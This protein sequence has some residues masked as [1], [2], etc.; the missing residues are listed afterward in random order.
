MICGADANIDRMS[1]NSDIDKLAENLFLH[2]VS[3]KKSFHIVTSQTT[4]KLIQYICDRPVLANQ[5]ISRGYV[6]GL[7]KL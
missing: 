1:K 6:V 2:Y 5:H 3:Q 7:N 4:Y